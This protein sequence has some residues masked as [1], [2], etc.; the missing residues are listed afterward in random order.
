M[1][2]V[3]DMKVGWNLG[4]TLE[5]TGVETGWGN[6]ATTKKMIDAIKNARFNTVRII[7]IVATLLIQPIWHVLK[8]L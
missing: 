8:L 2:L 6:P 1:A 7:L 5:S 4:N 3:K